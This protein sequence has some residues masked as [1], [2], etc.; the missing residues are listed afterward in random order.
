MENR[1]RDR[2]TSQEKERENSGTG[3]DFDRKIGRSE[4]LSEGS[5]GGG[6]RNKQEDRERNSNL[7][8]EES[9]RPSGDFDS[10]SGRSGNRIDRDSD[11][12]QSQNDRSRRGNSSEEH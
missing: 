7:G 3:A 10:S 6:M 4:N 8:N 2:K 9:R 5:E 1:E 11:L 12:N